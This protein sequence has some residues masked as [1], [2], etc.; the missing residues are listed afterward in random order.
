[1]ADKAPPPSSDM[2]LGTSP[3]RPTWPL[4]ALTLL[5]LVWFAVL[6]VLAIRYPAR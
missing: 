4:I 1:M 6:V 5:Y 3:R 2:P